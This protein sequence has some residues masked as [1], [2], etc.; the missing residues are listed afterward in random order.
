MIIA[1]YPYILIQLGCLFVCLYLFFM[2]I[3][4]AMD[5]CCYLLNS[6]ESKQNLCFLM[7]LLFLSEGKK[8]LDTA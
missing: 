6:I 3:A 5:G 1:I 7:F 8:L 2:E 4:T